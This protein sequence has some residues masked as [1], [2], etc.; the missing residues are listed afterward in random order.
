MRSNCTRRVCTLDVQRGGDET[1]AEFC[2][3]EQGLTGLAIMTGKKV[4]RLAPIEPQPLIAA[5]DEGS[6]AHAG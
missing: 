3:G 4:V 1:G 5:G 6:A 2:G